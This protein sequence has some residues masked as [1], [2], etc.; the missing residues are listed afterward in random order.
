MGHANPNATASWHIHH[1][2][3][4][5]WGRRFVAAAA[6]VRVVCLRSQRLLK[7]RQHICRRWLRSWAAGAGAI[8]I[9]GR[10][11]ALHYAELQLQHALLLAWLLDEPQHVARTEV[12][13]A[14]DF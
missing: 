5:S 6:C 4:S 13:S 14:G 9:R 11:G 12:H 7:G 2:R 8:S 3:G 1:L 10:G